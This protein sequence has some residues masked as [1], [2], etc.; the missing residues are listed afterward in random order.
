VT[1]GPN[2]KQV[3]KALDNYW[4]E[5]FP[6]DPIERVYIVYFF[7]SAFGKQPEEW[8]LHIHLIPRTKKLGRNNPADVAAWKMGKLTNERWFPNEYRLFARYGYRGHPE[9][10]R[11]LIDHLK[12]YMF[13]KRR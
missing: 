12:K 13:G 5:K 10:A 2:I 6:H 9:K 8:H 1:L 11:D 7:E 3:D 4:K